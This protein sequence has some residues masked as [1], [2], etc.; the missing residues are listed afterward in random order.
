MKEKRR[1]GGKER[2]FFRVRDLAKRRKEN[3]RKE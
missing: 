2:R 3:K 1:K